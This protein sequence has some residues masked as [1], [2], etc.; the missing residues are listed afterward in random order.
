MDREHFETIL[1]ALDFQRRDFE[2]RL[3]REPKTINR[4]PNPMHREYTRTLTEI[5]AAVEAV[6]ADRC[7]AWGVEPAT[8]G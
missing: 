8:G 2:R 7:V 3:T 1:N 5:A 6:E 4:K